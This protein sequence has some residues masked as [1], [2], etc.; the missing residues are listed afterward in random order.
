MLIYGGSGRYWME[1]LHTKQRQIR[2]PRWRKA[3]HGRSWAEAVAEMKAKRS[4][5][6][7]LKVIDSRVFPRM[8]A[9]S[10][11]CQKNS[12]PGT[13]HDI[14]VMGKGCGGS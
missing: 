6:V 7:E 9:T 13:E 3:H 2:T 4:Y 10:E 12:S 1:W 8:R 5:V 11:C 14:V